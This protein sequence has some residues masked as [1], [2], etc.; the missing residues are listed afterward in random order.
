MYE[1][2][3]EFHSELNGAQAFAYEVK[4]GSAVIWR[5][6]SRCMSLPGRQKIVGGT[7]VPKKQ[8]GAASEDDTKVV[9][10]EQIDGYPVTELAPYAFSAHMEERTLQQGIRTGKIR[11]YRPEW[12]SFA[13]TC[14]EGTSEKN[15]PEK[16]TFSDQ[17][18]DI[19]ESYLSGMTALCG[20]QLEEIFLPET[21]RRVGRYCFYDCSNLHRITFCGTLADWG[22]GVFTRCHQVRELCVST[23]AEGRSHL[24]DV[25]DELPEELLVE[26]RMPGVA[27]QN[28]GTSSAEEETAEEKTA[29][30]QMAAPIP[31]K[32]CERAFLVFPEFYEEG[33]ENTPARILETHVHGSGI[34]YRN[35]FQGRKFDFV[36]YDALFFQARAM[37]SSEVVMQMVTGRLWHPL[38]LTEKAR[39]QYQTYVFAHAKEFGDWLIARREMDGVRWLVELYKESDSNNQNL[40]L[41]EESGAEYSQISE[42]RNDAVISRNVLLTYMTERASALHYTEAVS[43]LMDAQRGSVVRKRKRLEL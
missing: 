2:E 40:S 26:Y 5:C 36:Q 39:L 33:V 4:Q 37:E 9:I 21:V 17:E 14:V 34:S 38:G 11:I 10:P 18:E 31:K 41:K 32:V 28:N 42:G 29:G 12:Y 27:K 43:Y 16:N 15:T 35:C 8:T 6:F 19:G 30:A 1:G 7:D 24:K 13:R 3:S 25:L 23:D 22:S 20:E